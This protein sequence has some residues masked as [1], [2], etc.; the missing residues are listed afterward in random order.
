MTLEYAIL[1][2]LNYQP[3]TG[4]DLKKVFD[5]SVDHFWHADQSQIYRTLARLMDQ[6]LVH[7]DIEEQ[8]E[9]PDRKVYSITVDGREKLRKWLAEPFPMEASHSTPLVQVF[10]CGQMDDEIVIRKF[11]ETISGLEMQMSIFDT[12]P[13]KVREFASMAS[14]DRELFYWFLTLEFGRRNLQM[15]IDWMESII[16]RI[17]KR[18][19]STDIGFDTEIKK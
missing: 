14:S 10:F 1:G 15:T 3:L 6:G 17:E 16:Q 12:I 7:V 2:F 9:R 5:R 13:E 19:Y 11:R 4:Y 18:D 8:T